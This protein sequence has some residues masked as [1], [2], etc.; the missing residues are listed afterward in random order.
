MYAQLKL[1][2]KHY[3]IVACDDADDDSKDW[4]IW[5]P[6]LIGSHFQYGIKSIRSEEAT[7]QPRMGEQG[8]TYCSAKKF[9]QCAEITGCSS[10][11]CGW[12]NAQDTKKYS[13]SQALPQVREYG[14]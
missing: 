11:P 1:F 4:S 8:K 6:G 7:L 10:F 13:A 12:G 2:R 3:S 9:H 5:Y 14:K